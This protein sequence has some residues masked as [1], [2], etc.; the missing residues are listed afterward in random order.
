MPAACLR[1]RC[2]GRQLFE[3]HNR[4]T[5]IWQ[6]CLMIHNLSRIAPPDEL[7]ST[8]AGD[9]KYSHD[10][11]LA[12]AR[13]DAALPEN[14]FHSMLTLERRRAERSRK[15]FVLMHSMRIWKMARLRRF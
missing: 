14:L 9:S 5:R 15:P 12:S 2:L 3:T 1:P 8:R 13:S 7:E 10:L 4:N 11:D 6:E